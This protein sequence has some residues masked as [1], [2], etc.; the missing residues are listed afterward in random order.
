LLK[1]AVEQELAPSYRQTNSKQT[2]SATIALREVTGWF[3]A[4][5]ASVLAIASWVPLSS[6][7]TLE[8]SITERRSRLIAEA[9]DVVQVRWQKPADESADG[10]FG[11]VVWSSRRQEG[12]MRISGL[13]KNDP[14]REQYQL[15]IFD[16]ARDANPIDGGVFDVSSDGEVIVPIQAKLAVGDPTLFAITIEKPGGVVVSDKSRLPLLAKVVQ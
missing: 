1:E 6:K 13:S 12:F 5:A 4:I 15:W 7:R 10:R 14:T 9:D 11:D 3:L 8:A 16:P 2:A